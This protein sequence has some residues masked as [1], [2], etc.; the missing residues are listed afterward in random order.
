MALVTGLIRRWPGT[1]E[2]D[3]LIDRAVVAD[4]G[5]LADNHADAVV[6]KQA[7]A[8]RRARMDVDR[9]QHPP[10]MGDKAPKE[11]KAVAP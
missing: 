2:G 10:D 6:D 9:G 3:A 5:G 8:D 1:A 11:I 4:L 7:L